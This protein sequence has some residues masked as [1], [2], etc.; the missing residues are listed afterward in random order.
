MRLLLDTH[1]VL[2]LVRGSLAKQHPKIA[3]CLADPSTVAFVSV[4]SL[5]E[6]IK[7]RLGKLDPG[8]P[9][10]DIAGYLM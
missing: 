9:L 1:V 7:V 2:G 3:D 10:E 6:T 8:M 4:P 5:W